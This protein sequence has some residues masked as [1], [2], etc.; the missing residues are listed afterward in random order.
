MY[1]CKC[2]Y[3]CESLCIFLRVCACILYR[4]M[5]VTNPIDN[6]PAICMSLMTSPTRGRESQWESS[7]HNL[8][9]LIDLPNCALIHSPSPLIS[10]TQCKYSFLLL[11]PSSIIH[12]HVYQV[13][14]QIGFKSQISQSI[15]PP[16]YYEEN[17]VSYPKLC[18]FFFL[19]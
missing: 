14:S 10:L 18:I 12:T 8:K 6:N 16:V 17:S 1:G 19:I 11:Y 9:R 2:I 4:Y 5:H 3:V 15:K 13:W 7:I